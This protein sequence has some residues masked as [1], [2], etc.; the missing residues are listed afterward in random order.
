[1]FLGRFQLT[2]INSIFFIQIPGKMELLLIIS[3]GDGSFQDRCLA[4]FQQ[5]M[6]VVDLHF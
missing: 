3:I 2:N 5:Q 4:L 1:M 6:H